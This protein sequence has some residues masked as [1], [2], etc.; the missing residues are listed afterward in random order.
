MKFIRKQ[1]SGLKNQ[2]NANTANVGFS[3]K[4]DF[5]TKIPSEAQKREIFI[6]IEE[7]FHFI[8][9]VLGDGIGL[10]DKTYMMHQ[11]RMQVGLIYIDSL[12]DKKI[13]SNHIVEPLLKQSDALTCGQEDILEA[14]N[15]RVIL[16][17]NTKASGQMEEVFSGLLSG[18]T[19]K[20]S[21]W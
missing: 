7:N 21:K 19:Q 1:K 9:T 2:A 16:V 3:E 6:S 14:L 13:V 11:N 17:P 20:K 10:I 4:E 18:S 15:T 12:I 8:K 5:K